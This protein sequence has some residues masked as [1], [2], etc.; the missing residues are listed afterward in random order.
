MNTIND[1]HTHTLNRINSRLEGSENG[2]V[3]WRTE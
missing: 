2:S 1:I 3:T